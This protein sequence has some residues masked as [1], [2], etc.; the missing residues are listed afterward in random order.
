MD[1]GT[2]LLFV[3][4]PYWN[5]LPAYRGK[6]LN[7]KTNWHTL[8]KDKIIEVVIYCYFIGLCRKKMSLS[9]G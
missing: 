9:I 1:R 3:L 2:S 4:K 8:L 6:V 7:H 5:N